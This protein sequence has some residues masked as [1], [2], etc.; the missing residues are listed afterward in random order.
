MTEKTIHDVGTIRIGVED[1]RLAR[2]D[3]FKQAWGKEQADEPPWE[4]GLPPLL[5]AEEETWHLGGFKSREGIPG[6]TEYGTT[7][8]RWPFQMLPGPHVVDLAMPAPDDDVTGFFEALGYIFVV[9]GER[10][11]R[12]DPSDFSVVLSKDFSSGV[13]TG[14]MGLRWEGTKGLVGCRVEMYEVT[15]IGNPDTWAIGTA[16]AYRLAAGIDRLFAV[17]YVGI[18]R[19]VSTGL[20]PTV[21]GNW[22][23]LVQCG[24]LY[25]AE[26]DQPTGL[27]VYENT[28]VVGRHTGVYGVS[29][30]EGIGVPLID[31]MV[32]DADNC[33][34]MTV[35]EPHIYVPHSRGLYR[36]VPGV[37]VESIGLEREVLNQM[38][39][40][41]SHFR[42]FVVDNQWVY[43]GLE[44]PSGVTSYI[45]VSRDRR[46]GEP[47]LGPV[48]WDTLIDLGAAT[49]VR[50]IH[51]STLPTQ[52]TLLFAKGKHV[53][54][55]KLPT[56][57]SVPGA[58][59]TFAASSVRY[60]PRYNFGDWNPKDFP[61]IQAAAKSVGSTRYWT[62]AYRIDDG[63]WVD[64]DYL[65]VLT[66]PGF[67]AGS[68][69]GWTKGGTGTAEASTEQAYAGTY[70]CKVNPNPNQGVW[71]YQTKGVPCVPG[72]RFKVAAAVFAS[73]FVTVSNLLVNWWTAAGAYISTSQGTDRGGDYGWQVVSD[74][75][76]A[77]ATA[78]YGRVGFRAY[79]TGTPAAA[80]V[81][82]FEMSAVMDIKSEGVK[83]FFLDSSAVGREIQY[84]RTYTGPAA[85]T[86]P[87]ALVYFRRFARPQSKK[88][89]VIKAILHL[90][91]GVRHDMARE[92]RDAI[93][94]FNDLIALSEQAES[95]PIH[96]DWEEDLRAW[97]RSIR[98][99]ETIQ[100]G[101]AEQEYLVEATLQERETA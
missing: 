74:V 87:A 27:V 76:T 15:V 68:I 14:I 38:S 84:R 21:L 9:G 18:L 99:L 75:V 78:A 64:T 92:G 90:A 19:N 101:T 71:A 31:R 32:W 98:L 97:V 55:I 2:T 23:D 57:G 28:V 82:S 67:E 44:G 89:P 46:Q 40:G 96:L 51:I 58:D 93:T 63:S 49:K 79:E 22:A 95:V 42:C 45:T 5:S 47:G 60:S 16:Y 85:D 41:R 59:C 35:V 83:T 72:Q 37:S 94:Q 62:I 20:N 10:V 1:Y 4:G 50:A 100:V 11:F 91:A 8:D 33:L 13:A 86:A 48:I 34:G 70:S 54:Y 7:D 65:R 43:A 81:D 69:E 52:P 6:T 73:E 17:D 36:L 25:N 39:L 61:K 26:G 24:P 29:A 3:E 12:I 88:V 77:P 53:S 66:N 56:S 30:D 80:Y